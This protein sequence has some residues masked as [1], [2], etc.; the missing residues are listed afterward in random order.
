MLY[1]G[2]YSYFFYGDW[3]DDLGK[4][5]HTGEVYMNGINMYEE[6]SVDL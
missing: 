3:Y 4:K 6:A 5:H 2:I 1:I